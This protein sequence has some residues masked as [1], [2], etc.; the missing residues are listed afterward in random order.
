MRLKPQ[1]HANHYRFPQPR[2]HQTVCPRHTP[3]HGRQYPFA[4]YTRCRIPRTNP[5]HRARSLRGSTRYDQHRKHRPPAIRQKRSRM[6]RIL[7]RTPNPPNSHGRHGTATTNRPRRH[8][9]PRKRR[10]IHH[11]PLERIPNRMGQTRSP[12]LELLSTQCRR[13]STVD[14]MG[15]QRN[16]IRF[17]PV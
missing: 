1:Q 13:L 9:H 8:K 3:Q 10:T 16:N 11:R 15:W 7:P 17:V 14:S 2:R 12:A 4:V 5:L 6:V